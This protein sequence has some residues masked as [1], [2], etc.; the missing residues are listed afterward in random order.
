[1]Y[2]VS[3]QHWGNFDAE[4]VY[5]SYNYRH[6]LDDTQPGKPAFNYTPWAPIIPDGNDPIPPE[7]LRFPEP[8]QQPLPPRH[9]NIQAL[10]ATEELPWHRPGSE[11]PQIKLD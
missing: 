9:C 4:Q 10:Y 11:R 6:P 3:G 2:N 5:K 8:G 7:A 1:M